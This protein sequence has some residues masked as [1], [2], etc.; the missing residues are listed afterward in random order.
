MSQK[1]QKYRNTNEL[2]K[3]FGKYYVR[4]VYDVRF[5]GTSDLADY[6]Q[7]QCTVKRSDIKAVLDELGAAFKHYFELGQKVKLDG[8]G[9]FKVGIS[10]ACSDTEEGC[11]ANLVKKCRVNFQPETTAVLTGVKEVQ[12]AQKVNGVA[13]LITTQMQ[14]FNHP[15]TMLKDVRF[16][17]TA[18]LQGSGM[19]DENS[20]N[21]G[22]SG[23]AGDDEPRP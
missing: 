6:I 12:R 5:V 17:L 23:N 21:G 14:V 22:N 3:T 7:T 1:V 13:T 4:P 15:A 10:S 2:S 16:E 20:G 18:D 19:Q 9:I 11:T 8:I